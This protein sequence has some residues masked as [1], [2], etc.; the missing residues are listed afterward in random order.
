MYFSG[1]VT[2]ESAM[3]TTH[4]IGSPVEFNFGVSVDWCV[5]LFWLLAAPVLQGVWE[6]LQSFGKSLGQL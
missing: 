3:T 6:L 5:C 1:K 2:G 4:D